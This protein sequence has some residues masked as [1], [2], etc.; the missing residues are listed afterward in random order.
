MQKTVNEIAIGRNSGVIAARSSDSVK[1]VQ[2][3]Y[4]HG[5]ILENVRILQIESNK[6]LI[7]LKADNPG[8][9]KNPMPMFMYDTKLPIKYIDCT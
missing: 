8:Q 6:I 4:V 3:S 9:D 5:R 2:E 1:I 7:Y